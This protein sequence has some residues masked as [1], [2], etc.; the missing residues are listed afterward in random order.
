MAM[1]GDEAFLKILLETFSQEAKE[2]TQRLSNGLLELENSSDAEQLN[3]TI[4]TLFREAHSLKGAARSV[5][6]SEIEEL[7]KGIED[8]FGKY[9]KSKEKIPKKLIDSLLS[10]VDFLSLLADAVPEKRVEYKPKVHEQIQTLAKLLEEVEDAP[11]AEP[12]LNAQP[13]VDQPITI[14]EP[15][16]TVEPILSAEPVVVAPSQDEKDTKITQPKVELL[17][18]KSIRV[19]VEKLNKIMLQSQEML[20]AKIVSQRHIEEIEK[21]FKETCEW[22]RES[23]NRASASHE[24]EFIM[25][26]RLMLLKEIEH[27]KRNARLVDIMVDRLLDEMKQA[28]MLPFSSLFFALPKTVHDMAVSVGKEAM[29]QVEGGEIEIDRRILEEMKDPLTHLLRNAI[30]HG[31]EMPQQREKAAKPVKGVITLSLTQISATKVSIVV[32]DD[33]AGID[34]KKLLETAVK[35]GMI[36]EK[37]AQEFD[38]K[39][40]L[41]LVFRSGV[42][43]SKIVSDLSGRGLG[44]AIVKEKTQGLGGV[45]TVQNLQKGG[46]EFTILLPLTLSTFRGILV[47][48]DEQRF[49]FPSVSVK[50]VIRVSAHEIK[51]IEEKETL[52]FNH[53]VI[54]FVLLRDLLLIQKKPDDKKDLVV[55]IVES[56]EELIGMGVD[57]ILYE[58]EVMVKPLSKQLSRVKNISGV[59]LLSSDKPALILNVQDLFKSMSIVKSTTDLSHKN[60]AVKK[61]KLLVVDDSPT[62]RILLKNVLQSAGYDVV[63]ANDGLEAFLELKKGGFDLLVSDIQMPKMNGFELTESVRKDKLLSELPVVLVTALDS[64]EDKE[65]GME[66]GANAY[67]IKS[68][69]DQNHLMETVKWL[70]K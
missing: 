66:A 2:Y 16:Q 62:T 47:A 24:K 58:E 54:P 30:D 21:I 1:V 35:K 29:L 43:T 8:V 42:T 38:E 13:S 36:N 20:F 48:V 3:Q 49:I 51:S 18:S 53:Q 37:E 28:L 61:R 33:G 45:V 65:K 17:E 68:S 4:E 6:I 10:S 55:V 9:K 52:L 67:I 12:V 39:S 60:E 50:K 59:A 23:E 57:E 22:V 11:S 19:S 14:T 34:S 56:G 32:R 69:F 25:T 70:I 63:S 31:I 15:I 64:A 7:C 44:L 5:N 27:S 26:L 46:C 40:V 41:S